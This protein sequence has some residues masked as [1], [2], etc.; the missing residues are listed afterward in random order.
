MIALSAKQLKPTV[1]VVARCHE[2]RNADKLRKAGADA[3]VSPDF[4]GGMRMATAMVRPTVQTFLDEMLRSEQK[5]RME[6][7]MVPARFVPRALGKLKL[8]DPEYVLLALRRRGAWIFNP[9]DDC[10]LEPGNILIVMASPHGLQAI[11]T[12]L[13]EA[14]A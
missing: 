10:L 4:T 12:R 14:P 11:E 1:R 2:I 7:V 8:R 13:A 3:I 5:L 9:A 6:E